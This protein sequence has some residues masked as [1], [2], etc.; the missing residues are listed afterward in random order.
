MKDILRA[1]IIANDADDLINKVAL[2]EKIPGIRVIRYNPKF[3]AAETN[4]EYK[5]LQN[6]TINFIWSNSFICELQVKLGK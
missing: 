4:N 2:F 3:Y 6:V 1:R 5:N